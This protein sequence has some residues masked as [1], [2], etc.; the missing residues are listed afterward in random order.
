MTKKKKIFLGV[1]GGC[2][3]VP[4]IVLALAWYLVGP[5]PGELPWNYP[6]AD[7]DPRLTREAA[8]ALP[9]IRGLDRYYQ[10]HAIFPPERNDFAP[11]L[12]EL[13]KAPAK[14][15]P[16]KVGWMY[17]RGMNGTTYSLYLKLGWDP[18]LQYQCDGSRG[19][20]QF[21]P[22]DGSEPKIIKL[23]P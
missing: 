12:P 17:S 6:A 9:L 2:L 3:A 1:A 11:D 8:K 21:D 16:H 15:R 23:K 13:P 19:Y 7:Y 4:M 22:G 18:T 14:P 10:A 20:W 5:T